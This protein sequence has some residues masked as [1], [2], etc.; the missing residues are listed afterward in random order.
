M[1]S[2]TTTFVLFLLAFYILWL[3][4][5][6]IFYSLADSSIANET[7]RLIF[8]NIVK[9]AVW[10]LPAMLY[11]AWLERENPFVGLKISTP[12][13]QRGLF[14]GALV[15]MLFLGIIFTGEYF[16][17]GRTLAPL[18]AASTGEWLLKLIQ[19]TPSPIA[20]EIMFRGFVL[21]QLSRRTDFFTA[22]LL[23]AILFTAMHWPNWLW[24]KGWKPEV[25]AASISVLAIGL[26]LG[27]LARRTN[28]IWPGVMVHIAN[29]FLVSFLA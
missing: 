17:S 20:E 13:H 1:K 11:T 25:L 26:L 18:L 10:V 28:S 6:T 19:V 23:Q 8:S 14:L 9:F 3:F 15:S 7:L 16:K 4:R 27:W 12:L 21:P 22:N 2:N 24:T 5:A 29:N